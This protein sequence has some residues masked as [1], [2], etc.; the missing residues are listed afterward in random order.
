MEEYF[1]CGADMRLHV[2]NRRGIRMRYDSHIM[3]EYNE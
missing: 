1:G 3:S 2:S